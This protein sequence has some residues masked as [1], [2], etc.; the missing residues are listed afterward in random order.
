MAGD[1]QIPVSGVK[2]SGAIELRS[3]LEQERLNRAE[4]AISKL[5]KRKSV[6][7]ILQA[8]I[9]GVVLAIVGYFLND[10]VNHAFQEKQLEYSNVKYM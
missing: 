4:A 9:P 10:S 2:L 6:W 8:I 3:S 1:A 5:E 7:E